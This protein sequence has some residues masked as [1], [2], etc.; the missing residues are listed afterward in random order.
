MSEKFRPPRLVVGQS[1]DR[2]VVGIPADP[3]RALDKLVENE[4][5]SLI[6]EGYFCCRKWMNNHCETREFRHVRTG[7]TLI[8][9]AFLTL[10]HFQLVD[11]KRILKDVTL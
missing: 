10:C 6:S 3:A 8:M 7:R 1:C 5:K 2:A 11:G 4:T 9:Y